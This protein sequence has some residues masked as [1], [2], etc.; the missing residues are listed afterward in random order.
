MPD[1]VG[2][3]Q[4]VSLSMQEFRL[5]AEIILDQ[6]G[7]RMSEKKQPLVA[8]RLARRLR[9]LQCGSYREY[10]D[11]LR[12]P[13]G[14]AE[15]EIFI[16]LITTHVTQFFR[17]PEHYAFLGQHLDA[18]KES[19]F[20]LWS[21]AASTGEEAYSAALVIADHLG[22]R[23]WHVFGSDIS[24]G[25]IARANAGLFPLSGID[26]IPPYYLKRYCMKGTGQQEGYFAFTPE[27]RAHVRF[28]VLN[29]LEFTHLPGAFTPHMVLL[30][31]VLIYFD[32]DKQQQVLNRVANVMPAGAILMVG[33]SESLATLKTPFRPLA[34]A[35]YERI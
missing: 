20:R 13:S 25:A 33:H 21:A 26:Q 5:L 29:L 30:R 8:G 24:N 7:I 31:N 14:G 34:T 15:L 4:E 3:H 16:D 2:A 22:E 9:E 32:A 6:T 35:I 28:E 1:R 18:T 12:S 27:I 11:I 23:P 17:E 10:A 19:P